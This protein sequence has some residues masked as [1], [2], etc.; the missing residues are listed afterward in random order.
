MIRFL[1][2][3]SVLSAFAPGRVA[4]PADTV[5][6]A[7]N[8]QGRWFVPTVALLEI[9]QGIS[10]LER[11]GSTN[12]F[13][14]LKVWSRDLRAR[15]ADRIVA[16]DTEAA[17]VAGSMSDRLIGIGRHPGLADVMI[18][19]TAEVRGLAVLTRNLQH[20]RSTG[21]PAFDPFSA[22]DDERPS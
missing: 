10:K 14:A 1:A 19:A 3:T 20:F 6:W 11:L 4:L 22:R 2:D 7:R 5:E 18:A 12:K 13:A 21:V 8:N 9:E 16:F 17:L 15:F